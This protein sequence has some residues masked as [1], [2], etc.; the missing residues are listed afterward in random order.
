MSAISSIPTITTNCSTR[1]A[2]GLLPAAFESVVDGEFS[3]LLVEPADG[4]PLEPLGQLT[5]AALE[6][7]KFRK[8]YE[9][10]MPSGGAET[11]RVLARWNN[12]ASAPAVLEKVVGDGQVLLWTVAADRGWSDW[13]TEASYVLAVRE[14]ARAVARS[15]ASLRQFMAGQVLSVELPATHDIT[16]AAVEMPGADEAV[17]LVLQSGEGADKSPARTP[18]TNPRGSLVG[19]YR[20][21]P[22]R[23]L[24]DDLA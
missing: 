1:T 3:G 9:V 21:P 14:A 11:T 13:P 4:S 15:T 19:L 5:P 8:F 24:Q 20:H 16:L 10:R 6:R 17:P 22:R 18:E 7:V 2:A 12:Q 23:A